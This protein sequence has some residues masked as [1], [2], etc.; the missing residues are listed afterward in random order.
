MLGHGQVNTSSRSSQNRSKFEAGAQSKIGV[1]L[2]GCFILS[3]LVVFL[4]C[5]WSTTPK[6]AFNKLVYAVLVVFLT[7]W[8]S[9]I[10]GLPQNL[11]RA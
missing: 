6:N 8:V 7:I 9:K 2:L 11:A 4:P 10:M 3:S 1:Y 5:R